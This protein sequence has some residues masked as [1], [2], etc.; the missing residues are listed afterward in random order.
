MKRVIT[1]S[2]FE[3]RTYT[4]CETDNGYQVFKNGNLVV[5]EV[6]TDTEAKQRI[7]ELLSKCDID[8]SQPADKSKPSTTP[9]RIL[10]ST[11]Y[12]KLRRKEVDLPTDKCY[13][14]YSALYSKYRGANNKLVNYLD[15]R[16]IVYFDK[17]SA[18]SSA[19]YGRSEFKVRAFTLP[20]S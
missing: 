18:E 19:K 9:T 13:I 17:H 6:L 16:M 4:I 10:K 1:S 20:S 7:D 12:G 5:N 15:D 11:Q 3:Y 14:L 8:E 2:C